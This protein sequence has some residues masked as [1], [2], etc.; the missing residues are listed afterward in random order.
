MN[1]VMHNSVNRSLWTPCCTSLDDDSFMCTM[2]HG[3][4]Q[5]LHVAY[6]N[7]CPRLNHCFVKLFIKSGKLNHIRFSPQNGKFISL[8]R[9]SRAVSAT[10]FKVD[11]ES[12]A[13]HR[14][15]MTAILFTTLHVYFSRRSFSV[16]RHYVAL[17]IYYAEACRH[18]SHREVRQNTPGM[19][20]NDQKF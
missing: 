20:S 6:R 16:S 18:R 14:P 13:V 11:N 3:L 7:S 19:P 12:F 17:S 9:L 1:I 10:S 8:C 15:E 5:A 4:Y 2:G